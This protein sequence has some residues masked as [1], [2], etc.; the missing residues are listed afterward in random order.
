MYMFTVYIYV[1][2]Y[3]YI[4]GHSSLGPEYW[5]PK[6]LMHFV[7]ADVLQNTL[8]VLFNGCFLPRC[9]V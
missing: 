2:I 9:L 8:L 5:H 6:V 7:S 3:I 1:Y 4:G